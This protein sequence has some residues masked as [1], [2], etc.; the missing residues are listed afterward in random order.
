MFYA[1]STITVT[2][3]GGGEGGGGGGGGRE[4]ER[5]KEKKKKK[6]VNIH[7]ARARAYTQA[8]THTHTHTQHTTHTHT[9]T[10][11]LSPPP[12]PTHWRTHAHAHA[13]RQ[14]SC[15]DVSYTLF[16]TGS[17]GQV[18]WGMAIRLPVI[19]VLTWHPILN[20]EASPRWMTRAVGGL[21]SFYM[22]PRAKRTH[23]EQRTHRAVT[24]VHGWL[25]N[26]MD[27]K[28]SVQWFDSWTRQG[29]RPID[30]C[31]DP[32]VPV[33]PPCEQHALTSLRRSIVSTFRYEKG[34]RPVT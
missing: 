9:H 29:K 12:P 6:G 13:R 2:G 33:S 26:A 3:G 19:S 17:F 4:R 23:T 22:Q 27:C 15:L 21:S 16:N 5:R 14:T 10:L 34:Y 1:Q 30:A 24:G 31:A 8:Y 25:A 20:N 7:N 18:L 28:S 32:S 11:Y